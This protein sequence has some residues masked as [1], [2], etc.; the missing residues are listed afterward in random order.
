MNKSNINYNLF[1]LN[2]KLCIHMYYVCIC[3]I[4]ILV[5]FNLI[6][7]ST[8]CYFHIFSTTKKA[9]NYAELN[10]F[11]YAK[12]DISNENVKRRK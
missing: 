4:Q 2:Y 7:F 3:G 1:L 6:T 5:Y 12:N 11:M 8:I 9:Y 10:T